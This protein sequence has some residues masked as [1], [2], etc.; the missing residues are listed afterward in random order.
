MPTRTSTTSAVPLLQTP[1]PISVPGAWFDQAAVDRVTRFFRT[2]RHTKGKWAGVRYDPA[3]WEVTYLLGP[4]FGW[5]HPDGSRIV[6]TAWWEMP[7]K[8]GKSTRGS[9]CGLYLTTAD[10]EIGAEVYSAAGDREQAGFVFEPAKAM[11][12]GSAALRQRI[13]P[14]KR[15]LVYP[16]T[17]S[18]F[19]VLSSGGE[20]K[21]GANVHGA[22]V[23]EVHIHKTRDL[24]DVLETGTGSREQ[25]LVIF[26]TTADDGTQTTIYA[27]KRT[28]LEQLAAGTVVDPTFYGVVFAATKDDDPFAERTWE[29]ANPGIDVTVKRE[30]L[31]AQAK[32]ARAIPGYLPTFQRLHLGI[33]TRA[34]GAWFSMEVWDRG[35]GLLQEDD[36][37]GQSCFGGIDL[38]ATIDFN[39]WML[40][41]PSQRKVLTRIFVPE[42]AVR[43]RPELEPTLRTWARQGYLTITDGDITDEA[44]IERQV[45]VDASRFRIHAVGYD[46]WNATSLVG[47]LE[48]KGLEMVRVGQG[49]ATLNAPSK[50]LETLVAVGD[51]NH[52]GHPVLR[53]M[54]GNVRKDED[55]SGNIKPSKKKSAEK[56]DGISGL[57]DALAV[58]LTVATEKTAPPATARAA[59][60]GTVRAELWR[61]AG[62]LDI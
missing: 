1:P 44:A 35:G 55:S 3:S 46:P 34:D 57:V 45:D 31:R 5:K 41:F 58:W 14:Y 43:R 61:P 6:R 50:K 11:A 4:V 20:L 62:R 19:K 59:A 60:G 52:G 47:R 38:A 28:Y 27:E 37:A 22:I 13:R 24:V 26:I 49:I 39:A 48:D 8:Q 30:Y 53:W 32:R 29:K 42:G 7:R 36:L 9:A 15:S 16:K 25:P 54:A 51:L 23:D 17:G 40:W 56:I 2:L 33:R 18:T 21:H 10:R 12:L